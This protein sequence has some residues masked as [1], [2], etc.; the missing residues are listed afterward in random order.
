M[1]KVRK[2][3]NANGEKNSENAKGNGRKD[4]PQQVPTR[5]VV[6][7]DPGLRFSYNS[8]QNVTLPY[9]TPFGAVRFRFAYKGLSVNIKNHTKL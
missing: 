3:A 6:F 9:W 4:A 2:Y 8:C 5:F 1:I 7:N